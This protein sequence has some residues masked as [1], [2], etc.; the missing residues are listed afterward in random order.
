MDRGMGDTQNASTA[1]VTISPSTTSDNANEVA[2]GWRWAD[3]LLGWAS[4]HPRIPLAIALVVGVLARA[5]FWLFARM[6]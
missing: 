1:D 6:R 5:A 4:Q 3:G 2:F